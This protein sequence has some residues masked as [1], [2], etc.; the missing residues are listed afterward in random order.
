MPNH[1]HAIIEILFSKH[2][3][4]SGGKGRDKGESGFKSPSQTIGAIIRGFKGATTKR[5][6]KYIR[7]LDQG[8]G[9]L[10][11]APTGIVPT[12]IDLSR[13]VWQRNYYEHII[14]NKKSHHIISNYI[15]NN[16]ANWRNDRF[17]KN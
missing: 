5:I 1:F 10:Q 3:E 12:G 17:Y 16:P 2:P 15:R 4:K 7:D 13:S 14:R 6:K 9:E 11:F 8:K